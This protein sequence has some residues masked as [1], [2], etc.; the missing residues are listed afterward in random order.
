[1]CVGVGMPLLREVGGVSG[2][3]GQ[4]CPSYGIGMC[5]GAGMPLLREV[6]GG[7]GKIRVECVR[8]R[9]RGFLVNRR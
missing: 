7:C 6:G 5:V 3:S 4:G 2:Q 9:W 8:K 1:M